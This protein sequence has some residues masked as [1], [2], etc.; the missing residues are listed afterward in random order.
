MLCIYIGTSMV[1]KKNDTPQFQK[2]PVVRAVANFALGCV[3]TSI[4]WWFFGGLLAC[5]FSGDSCV[6]GLIG[7]RD[8]EPR[9]YD[10]LG[11]YYAMSAVLLC[12]CPAALAIVLFLRARKE[13]ARAQT[14][15]V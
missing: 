5:K 14:S 12:V 13:K 4:L 7:L 2:S 3:A 1:A 15:Q 8:T 10:E 6:T 11:G 9:K